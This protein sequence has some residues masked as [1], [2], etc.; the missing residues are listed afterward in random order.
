MRLR[1]HHDVPV[2]FEPLGQ[3]R[4]GMAWY[5]AWPMAGPGEDQHA[6]QQP[7]IVPF[8]VCEMMVN[9]GFWHAAPGSD[10]Y[11]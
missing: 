2:V 10:Y 4:E 6:T 9:E 1:D 3:D 7:F 5:A 8:R 11:F